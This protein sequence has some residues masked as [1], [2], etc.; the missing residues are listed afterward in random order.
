M[1]R[2]F[3]EVD[4]FHYATGLSRMAIAFFGPVAVTVCTIIVLAVRIRD[5]RAV[6]ESDL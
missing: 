5:A 1:Q 2:F 4:G 3:E 6:R